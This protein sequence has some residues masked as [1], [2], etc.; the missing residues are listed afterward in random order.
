MSI[1]FFV[2]KNNSAKVSVCAENNYAELLRKPLFIRPQRRAAGFRE[3]ARKDCEA[4]ILCSAFLI[5]T[6][7][8]R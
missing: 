3:C 1:L 2:S 4:F 6:G 7:T 5:V 8:S